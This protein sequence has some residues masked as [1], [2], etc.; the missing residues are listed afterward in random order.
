M[1]NAILIFVSCTYFALLA[2]CGG[3]GG[4]SS[5]NTPTT[6][7]TKSG[8]LTDAAVTGVAYTTSSG[9]AGVTDAGIY[10]Y[11]PGD[12]VQFK[13]GGLVLGDVTAPGLGYVTATG[14]VTPIDLANGNPNILQNLLVL[15]QS[16]DAN[17]IPA[18]GISIPAAAAA[19]VTPAIDLKELPAT[20]NGALQAAMTA[21]N[22]TTPI[23]S[24]TDANTHFR[25]QVMP[26]LASNIWT[27]PLASDGT[28]ALLRVDARGAYLMGET[29]P[30]ASTG[31]PGV[32]LGTL[33]VP[34][35]DVFGFN[36]AATTT[37]DTSGDWGMSH[38]QS[39]DRMRPVGDELIFS[40]SVPA[41]NPDC[42]TSI[43]EAAVSKAENNP[44]GIVGVWAVGFAT[45]LNTQHVVFFSNGIF[46]L[47]DPLGDTTVGAGHPCGPPG[48]EQGSYTY[49]STARVFKAS[50]FTAN[51][52]G[53]AGLSESDA[54]TPI[55]LSLTISADGSTAV[56]VDGG[57][58][59]TLFRVSK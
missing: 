52:N 20:F 47:V 17:G 46:L 57:S 41:N 54:V 53:C 7:S 24:T 55:G 28:T 58:S 13:L 38:P 34:S 48:V 23:V 40:G 5:G 44:T 49:D 39:C 26:L 22:I 14:V 8:V 1:K 9:V 16:L 3:G 36:L 45:T 37:V 4:G 18:D 42:T 59:V 29:G 19:A 30:A 43:T 56:A 25:A 51:T 10:K 6:G 2:G 11:N 12:T 15:L 21:G 32:E 50:N 31:G 35:F 27:L 33:S